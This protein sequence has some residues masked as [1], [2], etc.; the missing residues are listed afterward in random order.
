MTVGYYYLR[1]G[2]SSQVTAVSV[3]PCEVSHFPPWGTCCT[4]LVAIIRTIQKPGEYVLHLKAALQLFVQLCLV[5]L[6]Q[7]INIDMEKSRLR[8][9][10]YYIPGY[11]VY[12]TAVTGA[13]YLSNCIGSITRYQVFLSAS[14]PFDYVRTNNVDHMYYMYQV[15]HIISYIPMPVSAGTIAAIPWYLWYIPEPVK[16]PR[17]SYIGLCLVLLLVSY[18]RSDIYFLI[19]LFCTICRAASRQDYTTSN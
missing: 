9:T 5:H 16:R 13:W 6:Y 15:I 3:Y 17:R 11:K 10:A 7:H 2:K 8:P 14:K 4:V 18:V 19:I 1:A 12:T